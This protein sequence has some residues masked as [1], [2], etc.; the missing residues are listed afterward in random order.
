MAVYHYR[1]S[2]RRFIHEIFER[3]TFNDSALARI[4][5]L[6]GLNYQ[7][8][9]DKDSGSFDFLS[10]ANSLGSS[11]TRSRNELNI[12]LAISK[13]KDEPAVLIPKRSIKGF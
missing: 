2:A 13:P 10:S 6:G 3:V 11:P 8:K 1:L 5:E 12:E 9:K 7:L 4:D